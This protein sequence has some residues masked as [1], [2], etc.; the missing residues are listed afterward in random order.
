LG[1]EYL[2]LYVRRKRG[3]LEQILDILMK[4]HKIEV[5]NEIHRRG[6]EIHNIVQGGV[7]L[8]SHLSD[9]THGMRGNE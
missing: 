4:K 2:Y 8:Y 5:W 6:K 9:G 3:V 7:F 1:A